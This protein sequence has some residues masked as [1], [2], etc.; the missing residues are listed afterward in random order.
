[1]RSWGGRLLFTFLLVVAGCSSDD[2]GGGD[3]DSAS[4]TTAAA[5]G[6]FSMLSYNVAGL[7]QEVSSENPEEHLPMISPL[8]NDYDV[9][10]TQEDFDWW[11]EDPDLSA[12]VS[13]L[14]FVHYHERL[15]AD[16]DFPYATERHPGPA[17]VGIDGSD[18]QRPMP[19]V[20]DGLGFL[21]RIPFHDVDRVPWTHCYGVLDGASDCLAM[22]GF[23]VATFTLAD[24]VTVDVYTLHAEAGEGPDDQ[25][26]QVENFQQLADYIVE[27]S[28]GHAVIVG[29]DTN[30]H[31]EPD[32]DQRAADTPVWE[33]FL[34][35]T[36]L[37]DTCDVVECPG[38]GQIDKVAFRNA[39]GL[40][41]EPQ[42]FE[43]PTGRFSGPDGEDLSDH[44]PVLVEWTW[45][46]DS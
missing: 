34:E 38:V 28:D 11:S 30:L 17:A 27:H 13:E 46:A 23:A 6:E 19:Y 24:G 8:L 29:G 12:N 22:K 10:M 37:T 44:P 35:A 42:S 43:H 36:G 1:V 21:S 33:G 14:D 25:P 45:T 4:T 7:P 20:G 5:S 16:T 32:H 9:V 2:G 40:T 18:P 39:D 31:L 26:I 3:G 15:R 41:L